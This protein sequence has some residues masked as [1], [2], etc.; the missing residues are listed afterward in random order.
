MKSLFFNL[1]FILFINNACAT[2]TNI[3]SAD[4]LIFN[5]SQATMVG[6]TL[7]FPISISSVD[8]IYSIDFS[9]KFDLIKFHYNTLIVHQSS[10]SATSNYNLGDSV[11]RFSSFSIDPIKN[12]ISLAS[13]NFNLLAGRGIK[14]G[15]INSIEAFLNGEPCVIKIVTNICQGES[16]LLNAPVTSGNTYLWS[17]GHTT[18]NIIVS[19]SGTYYATITNSCHSYNTNVTKVIVIPPPNN[20]VSANGSTTI[21]PGSSV[22][23]SVSGGSGKT[24]LWSNS[25]TS[26]VISVNSAGS[27]LVNITDINGCSSVSTPVI[28]KIK[29]I[30]GDFNT[31]GIVDV[32]DFLLL[33]GKYSTSCTCPEDINSDRIINVTDFLLLLSKYGTVCTS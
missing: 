13:I 24:F 1:A 12:N 31:D 8:T 15:E 33:I 9:L 20:M 32:S 22:V 16:L 3:N 30:Q 27:Y 26:Q 14:L 2:Q 10:L 23:L 19:N 25:S 17:T 11:L 29:K 5:L 4:T 28:V 6:N 7:Q 18:S 21:C